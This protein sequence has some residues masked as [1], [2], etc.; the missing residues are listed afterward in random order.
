MNNKAIKNCLWF[1][2]CIEAREVQIHTAAN[3]S[4]G[5][6]ILNPVA[7]QLAIMITL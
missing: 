3:W 2:D 6:F 7:R 4:S 1:L 5:G